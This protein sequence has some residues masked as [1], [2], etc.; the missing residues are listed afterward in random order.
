MMKGK[1]RRRLKVSVDDA[2]R[3]SFGAVVSF[4]SVGLHGRPVTIHWCSPHV[5]LVVCAT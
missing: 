2:E 4:A 1:F 3:A 5:V